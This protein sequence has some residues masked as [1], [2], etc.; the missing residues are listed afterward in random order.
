M[1]LNEYAL[2]FTT[3]TLSDIT[4]LVGERVITYGECAEV[5]EE[6][7]LQKHPWIDA[8]NLYGAVRKL[9]SDAKDYCRRLVGLGRMLG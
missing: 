4:G 2:G 1:T 9:S 8:D 5:L 7:L 3:Y 6:R